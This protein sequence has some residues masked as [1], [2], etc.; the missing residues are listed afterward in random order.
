M[1]PTKR[2]NPAN[3][4]TGSRLGQMQEQVSHVPEHMREYID[5]QPLAAVCTAFGVGLIAGVGLVALYCQSQHQQTTVESLSQR[6]ADAVRS[7]MP[8][9]L[10]AFQQHL[11]SFR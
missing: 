1:N 3:G 2:A 5:D 8:Q 7:A 6:I 11:P 4:Q 9:N 10:A